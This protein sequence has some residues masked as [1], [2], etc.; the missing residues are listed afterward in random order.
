LKC[1]IEKLKVVALFTPNRKAQPILEKLYNSF[2][3]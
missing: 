2:R 1:V 3:C